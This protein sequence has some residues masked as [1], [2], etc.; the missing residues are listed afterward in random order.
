MEAGFKEVAMKIELK[1]YANEDWAL[2]VCANEDYVEL[3]TSHTRG[4]NC[5]IQ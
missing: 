4:V 5:V 3:K 1:V 2:R